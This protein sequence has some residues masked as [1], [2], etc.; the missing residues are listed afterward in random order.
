MDTDC[1]KEVDEL[2]NRYFSEKRKIIREEMDKDIDFYG[3]SEEVYEE[4]YFNHERIEELL[5]KTNMEENKIYNK[6]DK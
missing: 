3:D 5:S 4:N 1:Q 2:W 6:Y